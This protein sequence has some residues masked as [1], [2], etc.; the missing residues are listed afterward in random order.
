L[1]AFFRRGP[2][3]LAGLAARPFLGG[4][5]EE[6][7]RRRERLERA[8]DNAATPVGLAGLAAAGMLILL[9]LLAH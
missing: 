5:P 9:F 6:A 8:L 2:Q 4:P 1:G 7:A 3:R